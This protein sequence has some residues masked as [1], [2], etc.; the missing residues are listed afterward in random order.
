MI[1]TRKNT[2]RSFLMIKIIVVAVVQLSVVGFLDEIASKTQVQ[3][4]FRGIAILAIAMA[5]AY[6][7]TLMVDA[8]KRKVQS[9]LEEFDDFEELELTPASKAD[10]HL[11]MATPAQKERSLGGVIG[12]S[13]T[14][15]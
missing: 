7:F 8:A 3:Q 14:H 9:G 5:T 12:K 10:A 15:R 4:P 1:I 6:P 11:Q 2:D 13:T